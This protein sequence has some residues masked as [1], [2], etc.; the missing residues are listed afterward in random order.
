MDDAAVIDFFLRMYKEHKLSCTLAVSTESNPVKELILSLDK[1]RQERPRSLQIKVMKQVLPSSMPKKGIEALS[2]F[3]VQFVSKLPFPINR[4]AAREVE[5]LIL[6]INRTLELPGFEVSELDEAVFY[7][8]AWIIGEKGLDKHIV[9]GITGVILMTLDLLSDMIEKIA[10]GAITF[11][12]A[13]EM[14]LGIRDK[15]TGD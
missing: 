7:R 1:D 11:N 9:L 15:M 14:A 8:Y 10:S 2:Y 12:Q 4:M 3:H 5:S 13:L 6:F